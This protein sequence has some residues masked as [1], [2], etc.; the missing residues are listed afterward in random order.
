[1]NIPVFTAAGQKKGTMDLPSTLFSET[2]NKALMHQ[3]IIMQQSNRRIAIAHVKTRGEVIGTT[4]KAFQQKHTG[5]ARRGALRS[6]LLRGGGKTFGPRN[7]RNFRKDMPRSMRHAALRSCLGFQAKR[8][9]IIAVE[10][11]P[12]TVKTKE[13]Y[14]LLKKLPVELGRHILV[15]TGDA[16]KGIM[17][18]ARN[19]DRVKTIT[20]AYLNP[21]DVLL[22]RHVIFLVDAIKKAD[23]IFGMKDEAKTED[24]KEA[25]KVS[26]AS[27]SAAKAKAMKPK[28][29]VVKAAKKVVAPKKKSSPS[30]K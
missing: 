17:L 8:D 1:M 12:D 4:K 20:A 27:V 23:E 2:I 26:R 11:Y 18:S 9:G 25:K 15:V 22:S 7:D 6:P 14:A 21:E 16:H 5:R 3:A 13:F 19:I 29:D 28:N 30:S 24:K 10:S